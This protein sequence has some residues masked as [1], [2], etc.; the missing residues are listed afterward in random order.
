[1]KLEPENRLD[2]LEMIRESVEEFGKK[3]SIPN[4]VVGNVN[5]ILEELFVNIVNYA[6][7]D[8]EVHI[9]EISLNEDDGKLKIQI[10]DDGK[11]FDPFKKD[12][13][14]TDLSAEEREIG[15]L[16]IYFVKT[17]MDEYLYR[18]IKGKNVI[19]LYKYLDPEG[20]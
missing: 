9:V 7:E 18:R 5:L 8:D 16:G 15:G 17:M 1:M 19:T 20:E 2:R 4:E 3:N 11:P 10:A 14:D 6:Y 13:P 12:D